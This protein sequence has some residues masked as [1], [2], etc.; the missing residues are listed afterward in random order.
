MRS[1]L[2]SKRKLAVILIVIVAV[3]T[4]GLSSYVLMNMEQSSQQKYLLNV[5]SFQTGQSRIVSGAPNI[6]EILYGLGLGDYIVG[7]TV[8][9]DYPPALVQRVAL[10]Q[11]DNRLDWWN[12]SLE[13]VLSL[14]PSTVL[15]DEGQSNQRAMYSTLLT[16]MISQ[17]VLACIPYKVLQGNTISQIET[18]IFLVA[19]IFGRTSEAQALVDKMETK[20]STIQGNVSGQPVL[21]VLVCVWINFAQNQVYTCGN[22][23]FLSEIVQKAGGLNVFYDNPQSWPVVTLAA[24]AAKNPDKIIIIDHYAYLDPS[25]T[26]S[27]IKDSNLGNT[28]A[29]INDEIYFVQGQAE[30]LFS[31]PG[32]RVAEGVELLANILFPLLFNA[33]FSGPPY[34][35]DTGNYKGY[36]DSFILE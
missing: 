10:R 19:N 16:L 27:K 5:F 33:T 26:R 8:Q 12:P 29:A 21:N 7:C 20:I 4:T 18:S 3:S 34:K 32:P 17:G 2:G 11:V 28:P 23:T 25:T 24:A 6:D 36:L 1:I 22:S 13:I 30:N 9:S 15:L 14:I 31:R 35:L